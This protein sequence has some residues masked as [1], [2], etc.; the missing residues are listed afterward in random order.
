VNPRNLKIFSL[1]SCLE[2]II[3]I[4]LYFQ[5][6]SMERNALLFGY[7]F[8][9]LAIGAGFLLVI[10]C[11]AFFTGSLILNRTWRERVVNWFDALF[12]DEK[13]LLVSIVT[14]LF[15]ILYGIGCIWLLAKPVRF[16]IDLN[17]LVVVFE[18][19]RGIATWLLI[20]MAQSL[21]L[22]II[23]YSE[24]LRKKEFLNTRLI[25][26]TL[27][28]LVIAGISLVHW[29]ILIFQIQVFVSIPYWTWFFHPKSTN[30]FVVFFLFILS[31]GV[32]YWILK[33]T[34]KIKRNLFLVILLGFILQAGYGFVEGMGFESLRQKSINAGHVKYLEYAVDKPQFKNIIFNYEAS[35]GWDTYLGTKPPGVLLF[36]TVVQRISNIVRPE[37]TYDGRFQRL[38]TFDA[39][40]FPFLTFLSL[41]PLYFLSKEFL[42]KEEAILPA[43]FLIFFPNV[44]LMP[45]ELDIV[46]FPALFLTGLLFAWQTIKRNSLVWAI[47]TGAIL[48]MIL[49]FSF[50]LLPLIPMVFAWLGVDFWLKRREK[51]YWRNTLQN[52]LGILAGFLILFVVFRFLMN[53]DLILRYQTAFQHHRTLKELQTGIQQLL[54]ALYL[55]NLEISAWISF[56]IAALVLLQFGRS[57]FALV[58]G[59]ASAFDSLAIAFT[60]MYIAVNLFGQ[61]RGEVG[62]LWIFMTPLFALFAIKEAG[63]LFQ[64]KE[65][66]IAYLCLLQFVLIFLTFK[67]QDYW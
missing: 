16:T 42:N 33:N 15:T 45:L 43:L 54:A 17:M 40:L 13:R 46:L 3:A 51:N 47:L 14:V 48:Y 59:K 53:Y 36:Y 62:R 26:K 57:I 2:G 61:T 64:R 44:V 55:N 27:L 22:L 34:G 58:K 6:R 23:S 5:D 1:L 20:V 41:I 25:V 31:V 24:V 37:L 38:S 4:F 28:V 52:G 65:A 67:F 30:Y 11:A 21:G 18:R 32:V 49:Y 56:P 66:G 10:L 7:S 63:Y 29:A 39:F 60:L 12:R 35:Y 19:V 8:S 50:S 9:R